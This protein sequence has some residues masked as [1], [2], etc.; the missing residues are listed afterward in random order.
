MT[1]DAIELC[2]AR[3]KLR[4]AIRVMNQTFD[5]LGLEQHPDTTCIGRTARGFDFL[6]YHLAPGSVTLAAQ[7]LHRMEQTAL[8]LYEQEPQ[9][10]QARV[11]RLGAYLLRWRRW[12]TA[13]LGTAQHQIR[14]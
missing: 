9:D 5:E 6:G 11:L 4:T 13:G 10:A 2:S 12:T 1:N 8:R 7:T 14:G 3:W